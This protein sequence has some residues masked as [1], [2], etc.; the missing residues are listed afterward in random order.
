MKLRIS[1]RYKVMLTILALLL[2]AIATFLYLAT[3]LF[4]ADKL[5]YI[6]DRN[7]SLVQTLSD[8]TRSELV[9]LVKQLSLFGRS[10]LRAGDDPPARLAAAKDVFSD[11]NDVVH[12]VIYRRAHGNGT[13]AKDFEYFERKRLEELAISSD[14]LDRNALERPLPMAMLVAAPGQ[15]FVQNSSLPP[16]AALL[17]L[18]V[19]LPSDQLDLVVACDVTPERLLRIFTASTINRSFLI[20]GQ[21]V[22]LIHPDPSKVLERA[23]LTSDGLVRAAL[24]SKV[25]SGSRELQL[26]NGEVVLGAYAQLGIGRL[27]ALTEIPRQQALAASRELLKRSGLFAAAIFFA[28]LVASVFFSRALTARLRK[29]RAATETLSSGRFDVNVDVRGRDE[30][31]DLARAFSEM[32]KALKQAQVQLVR[33]EKLAAFGQLGAGITH[34]VKNPMT[35]ILGFAQIAQQ[36]LDDKP[37]LKELLQL[38]ET[39]TKRCRDILVNFLK[40]AR[41]GSVEFAALDVNQVVSETAKIVNHQLMIHKVKLQIDLGQDVPQVHGNLQE[42]QQV[43]FNLA[44]NAQ[45]AM[46]DGGQV[47]I[48]T[49]RSNGEAVIEV[50]DDGPGIPDEVQKHLFEP[51]FTT[52]P[53]GEGTGLGLSICYGIVRDHRGTIAVHSTVGKGTIF[54][55]RLPA[56]Q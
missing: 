30:I 36:K 19:S 29:L 40:F 53:P 16:D 7:T 54:T 17:T 43:V 44:I 49:T 45:Q 50:A 6:Y 27:V 33:S 31:G 2:A 8:Q 46:A 34:E 39:E 32:A 51:F 21:G 1:I 9:V 55:V 13:F 22:A 24:E 25:A 15:V 28:A 20:D 3:T 14:D 4:N 23:S 37:K 52:K 47:K 11:S 35:G 5:V 56:Q 12:A 10:V 48:S 18:A 38:I 41:Q 42:L 26:D